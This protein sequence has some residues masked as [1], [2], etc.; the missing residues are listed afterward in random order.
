MDRFDA[1]RV[2]ELESSLRRE[3]LKV[4]DLRIQLEERLTR[5]QDL[6]L[7]IQTLRADRDRFMSMYQALVTTK[8]F[9]YTSFMRNIY[10]R[11]RSTNPVHH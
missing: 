5:I 10:G 3:E 11:V 6:R 7:E 9:R 8:T 1:E 4:A 2:E